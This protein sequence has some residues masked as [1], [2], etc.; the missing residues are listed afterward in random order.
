MTELHEA[1]RCVSGGVNP[2]SELS[3][4]LARFGYPIHTHFVSRFDNSL[5][6][7]FT[8]AFSSTISCILAHTLALAS[9]EIKCHTHSNWAKVAARAASD[10]VQDL[11]Y[12]G[13]LHCSL[14]KKGEVAGSFDPST[15]HR[16]E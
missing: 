9:L 11:T 12:F 15:C 1:G 3:S 4:K 6:N 16:S 8:K 5:E 2:G 7:A 14:H 13:L 10:P